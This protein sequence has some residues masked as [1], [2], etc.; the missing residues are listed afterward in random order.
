[1]KKRLIAV[2]YLLCQAVLSYPQQKATIRI[3]AIKGPKPFTSLELNNDPGN[4]QFAI[5]TDRTGGHRPGVFADGIKKINL[6][7]PEFVMS[8]G[9]LIEGY[10]TDIP[11]L[12]A[13]WKEFN[14]F[15]EQLEMPFF[16]VPGN[17]DITNKVM[18]D[19]WKELYGKTYYSFVYQNVLFLC[20]N[21]EDNYRGAGKGT[22]DDAQY[23]WIAQ[24]LAENKEVKWTLVFMHQP[25]WDQQAETK[26]WP[27]VEKLLATRKHTVY[28]GHR[29][30]FVQYERNKGKYYILATTGGGSRL[31]G[32]ELGEFDHV[33]WI[34]MTDRGPIMANLQLEGIWPEDVVTEKMKSFFYPMVNEN[35]VR[36][37]PLLMDKSAF[38]EGALDINITNDSNVPMK[39]QLEF[40]YN[41]QLFPS[42]ARATY[43][44]EPN[45]IEN[46]SLNLNT[47][48]PVT[49]EALE[50]LVL[51]AK[52]SY[53]PTNLPTV[54]ADYQMKIKPERTHLL[55]QTPEKVRIDGVLDEWKVLRNSTAGSKFIRTDPFSHSGDQDGSFRFE[56]RYDAE[57]LYVAAAIQ[58]DDI[59]LNKDNFPL[60]QDAFHVSLDAGLTGADSPDNGM[61]HIT[62]S[63]G[64]NGTKN[65]RLFRKA[66]LPEGTKVV[67]ATTNNG[68]TTEMAIPMRFIREIQGKHWQTIR[69]NCWQTDYD[70]GGVHKS[71]IFWQPDWRGAANHVGSGTFKKE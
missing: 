23:E 64:A 52:V 57:Y 48:K 55:A 11:T 24:I 41:L 43:E 59:Y 29:H 18:K 65:E 46:V 50:A 17:H 68:Y 19:K 4:F 12:D 38:R 21:S 2:I 56:V 15:I 54:R 42:V 44:I 28:A 39:A 26:R 37:K 47:P 40:K 69:I 61:L 10:T 71:S 62:T 6:L 45:S 14:G 53:H 33:A 49:L 60:S 9:D 34:T 27:D 32:P 31:R 25:L 3:E 7:Q 63:P 5:V 67:T 22:I 36:I 30:S 1:M 58:D 35:P 66:Q 20:L 8:V 51:E 16:Y 70:K 13:Q